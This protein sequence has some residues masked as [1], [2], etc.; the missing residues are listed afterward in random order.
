[1]N[2]PIDWEKEFD[3]KFRDELRDTGGYSAARVV[4]SFITNLLT[5][6]NA[7]LIQRLEEEKISQKSI[8][9]YSEYNNT[10][11]AMDKGRMMGFNSGLSKAI[12]LIKFHE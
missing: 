10:D 7:S 3:E 4:K 11:D 2:T 9:S 8:D 12:E 5:S 1:M 6:H